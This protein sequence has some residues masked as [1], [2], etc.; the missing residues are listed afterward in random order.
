M[1]WL[2]AFL[3]PSLF[4]LVVALVAASPNREVWARRLLW[5]G[6]VTPFMFYV[7][8]TRE[9]VADVDLG[10]IDALR[11]LLPFG[12][13]LIGLTFSRPKRRRMGLPEWA[14]VAFI[15][16]A[17]ISALWSIN[18]QATA[19][20]V[21]PLCLQVALC[22][23]ISRRYRSL[24]D[25]VDALAAFL[26]SLMGSVIL[27]AIF[28]PSGAFGRYSPSP[29][30]RLWGLFPQIHPNTVATLGV[31]ALLAAICSVGPLERRSPGLQFGAI[32]VLVFVV[33]ASRSRASL[34]VGGLV[35]V[36]TMVR[37]ARRR[38][39][40][41]LA[42][43][44]IATAAPPLIVAFAGSVAT[45]MA[46]DQTA[47][48]LMSLTGRRDIWAAALRVWWERPWLGLGYY[49]GHRVGAGWASSSNLDNVWVESLLDVGVVGTI[50]LAVFASV[51]AH[52]LW[53]SA[54][55]ARPG[56]MYFIQGSLAI[57]LIATLYNPSFQ[58][59]QLVGAVLTVLLL[60]PSDETD[61]RGDAGGNQRRK[62]S[63]NVV[64]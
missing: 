24:D 46:R 59:V 41:V 39:G 17:E 7:R 34:I 55:G 57:L 64:R 8:S 6:L 36:L 48:Q 40:S 3:G 28:F 26:F 29:P 14:L 4:V 13:L 27:G 22:A 1:I 52:R 19:L 58:M 61:A 12:C 25:A 31:L 18:A 56:Y 42:L 16:F 47:A 51:G 38:S 33:L 23:A 15:A 54:R 49:S 43:S 9:E 60:S 20:K 62:P 50:L 35:I 21:V 45:F 10:L 2:A 63:G 44:G 11:V 5:F 32:G 53:I 37:L 30:Q